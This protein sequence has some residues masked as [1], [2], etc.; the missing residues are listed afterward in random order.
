MI[1]LYSQNF[2]IVCL[3]LLTLTNSGLPFQTSFEFIKKTFEN[4]NHN[5]TNPQF[6]KSQEALNL[7]TSMSLLAVGK[8]FTY[9]S[10]NALLDEKKIPEIEMPLIMNAIFNVTN[11]VYSATTE[12]HGEHTCEKK[13]HCKHC[14]SLHQGSLKKALAVNAATLLWQKIPYAG[15]IYTADLEKDPCTPQTIFV[16]LLARE[17]VKSW[18]YAYTPP[19]NCCKQNHKTKR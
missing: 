8:L 15:N 9:F 19:C 7:Y 1:K 2:T 11:G 12:K 10:K 6:Y 3:S 14:N 16:S 5:I 18:T 17:T 13:I 4:V